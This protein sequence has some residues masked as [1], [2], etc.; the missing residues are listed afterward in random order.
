MASKSFTIP[1]IFTAVDNMSAT[2]AGIHKS[3]QNFANKTNVGLA[4]AERGFRGLLSP[5]AAVN[6]LL[7]GFGIFIGGYTIYRTIAGL[8][9]IFSTFE[10]ANANLAAIMGTTVQQNIA[11]SN[12]AK[13]LGLTTS[14]T[15]TEVVG[16]QIELAKL[17]FTQEQILNMS[18]AIVQGSV[19][20]DAS[21]DRTALLTG[22]MTRTFQN[23]SKT[24]SDTQHIMDVMALAANDTALDFKKLET[25]LPIV[26]GAANAVGLSFERTVALL[27]ALSNAGIDASMSATALRNILIDSRRKGHTYDQVL[28]NIARHVD[29]LTP[30]F[31]K[32]GRRTAVSAQILVQNLKS[33]EVEAQRLT[34]VQSGYVDLIATKRLDTYIGSVTL[35]KAAYQGLV[36]SIEDGT[37]GYAKFLTNLNK[38]ARAFLLILTNTPAAREEL[39]R[40]N[41]NIVDAAYRWMSWLKILGTL[42]GVFAVLRTALYIATTAQWLFNA[43]MSANPV[44]MI[45]VTI[46]A[47]ITYLRIATENWD[48]FGQAMTINLGI[49]G[50]IFTVFKNIYDQWSKLEM[51]FKSYGVK[52]FFVELGLIISK[53]IVTP[54]KQL[55]ETLSSIP[56]LGFLAKSASGFGKTEQI[57][58]KYIN[59]IGK[60][61]PNISLPGEALGATQTFNPQNVAP[62]WRQIFDPN[63][64]RQQM[65]IQRMETTQRQ[66]TTI[67]LKAPNG[68]GAKVDGPT[69]MVPIKVS[70]TMSPWE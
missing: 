28:S 21:L 55:F 67:E 47:L 52:G 18:R 4:R 51:S 23:F 56:G 12:S 54:I 30:A 43:A 26:G 19:A 13:Q 17:G 49:A 60:A 33:V 69:N 7:G 41:N 70:S 5:I 27:G 22:A 6:R 62:E 3:M 61:K 57:L 29:T 66:Q 32:F 53:S 68:W 50:A 8:I 25:G 44:G 39:V 36:L 10:Q 37:N 16:L 59:S 63:Y 58:D 65:L 35:L 1:T 31:D 45:I 46:T 38:T 40:M 9:T 42:I 24:G 14:K 15:A 64:A 2:I 34:K 20:L 48:S 11:L